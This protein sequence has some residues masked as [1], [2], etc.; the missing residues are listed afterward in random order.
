MSYEYG[1]RGF[2]VPNPFRF[3]GL[4]GALRG[5]FLAALGTLLL[6]G[7][8]EQIAAGGRAVGFWQLGIGVLLLAVGLAAVGAGLNRAF[9][10]F[11]GRG[12]P[13]GLQPDIE[14][15]GVRRRERRDAD[16]VYQPGDVEQMLMGRKNLTFAEPVGWVE[17]ALNAAV[18]HLLFLPAP[19]RQTTHR[20]VGL[21]LRSA[22][23]GAILGLA[24]FS[25][26]TGLVPFEGTPIPAWLGWIALASLA[27]PLLQLPRRRDI[28]AS[29][30][31]RLSGRILAL[32]VAGA[33]LGP[34][35]L[36]Q[37]HQ[38]SPL[39][40][41]PFSAY[42]LLAATFGLA[43]VTG[44]YGLVLALLRAPR[45]APP[46]E[47]SELRDQWDESIHPQDLFRA[48]DMTMADH[49]YEE[50][51]NRVY[52]EAEASLVAKGGQDR[53]QFKGESLQEV[54]PRPSRLPFGGP[55]LRASKIGGT[56]AGHV[57][58][59]GGGGLLYW[60]GMGVGARPVDQLA[61]AGGL[62][63]LCLVFGAALSA[64]AWIHWAEVPFESDLVHFF[65]HGTYA[66][67]KVSHGMGILDS[68]R[69][70]NTVVRSS[71]TPWVLAAYV[72]TV[73]FARLG[74]RNLEGPRYLIG[75]ERND[76][77]LQSVAKGLREAIESKELVAD[78]AGSQADL[79]AAAKVHQLNQQSRPDLGA[80]L[81]LGAGSGG[82]RLAGAAGS[83]PDPAGDSPSGA[84][85]APAPTATGRPGV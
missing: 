46:T 56:L 40:E 20:A 34:V 44:A 83:A 35:A 4:V 19:L 74:A 43:L 12:V 24:L 75:L 71:L 76:G 58:A 16:M 52:V 82:A 26:S 3:D 48:F 11:V 65:A 7:I 62:A 63:L 18:P 60:V 30:V 55:T 13:Q 29:D 31:S 77:L 61:Q 6:L 27:F 5:T 33:L 21:A 47:V 10:F 17:R 51:P 70:E 66:E 49:R 39:P 67:S 9:R 81:G 23:V 85:D 68:S 69:S 1:S 45:Q 14:K 2:E 84:G 8:R 28:G 73:T 38:Q 41:P 15:A 37:V 53:G 54:Q 80:Q 57:V 50:M 64:M 36:L 59:A 42:P 78:V 25:G 22:L 72:H 32:L 79:E